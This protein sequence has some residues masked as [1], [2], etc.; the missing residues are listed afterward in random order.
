M[1]ATGFWPY[2]QRLS[3]AVKR[4]KRQRDELAAFVVELLE[5]S[6]AATQTE[7]AERAGVSWASLSGWKTGRIVPDGY[8]LLRL[9]RAA[10]L[11]ATPAASL[12]DSETAAALEHIR[13]GL[14]ALRSSVELALT[15]REAGAPP[16]GDQQVRTVRRRSPRVKP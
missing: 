12:T 1:A 11:A 13:E 6:G 15:R 8:N 5:R 7:F 16:P 14:D 10:G 2:R 3:V 4:S 9:I